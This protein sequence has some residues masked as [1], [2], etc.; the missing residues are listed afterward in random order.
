MVG[1]GGIISH[2]LTDGGFMVICPPCNHR[3]FD[4][5]RIMIKFIGSDLPRESCQTSALNC[6]KIHRNKAHVNRL[7]HKQQDDTK[8]ALFEAMK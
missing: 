3:F 7:L 4:N 1:R 8:E 2:V 6:R 5:A